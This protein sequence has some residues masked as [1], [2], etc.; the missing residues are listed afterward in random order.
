MAPLA[1]AAALVP[2]FSLP[3]SP[4]FLGRLAGEPAMA[5]PA[6]AAMGVIL[7]AFTV[8][9]CGFLLVNHAHR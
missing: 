3:A 6:A 7:D 5:W 2:F 1:A 8:I 4:W 9:L